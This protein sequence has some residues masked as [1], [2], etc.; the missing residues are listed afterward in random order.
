M[1]RPRPLALGLVPDEQRITCNPCLHTRTR[2]SE[3]AVA[4]RLPV[5]EL[6][7][8]SLRPLQT[9]PIEFIF[10]GGR[11]KVIIFVCV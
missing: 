5:N 6:G 11:D 4:Q 1:Q 2:S 7:V 3:S 9:S 8:C 10:A